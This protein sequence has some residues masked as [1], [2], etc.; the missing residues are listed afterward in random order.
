MPHHYLPPSSPHHTHVHDIS[1]PVAGLGISSRNISDEIEEKFGVTV[2][3]ASVAA[4]LRMLST[5]GAVEETTETKDGDMRWRSRRGVAIKK[6]QAAAR[7]VGK[8]KKVRRNHRRG[9]AERRMAAS[10]GGPKA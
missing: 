7:F 5:T 8:A 6:F 1:L 10:A 9:A 3:A 4:E 2:R